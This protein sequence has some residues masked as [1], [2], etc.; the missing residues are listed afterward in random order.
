[1][2]ASSKISESWWCTGTIA[3]FKLREPC[4]KHTFMSHRPLVPRR[5]QGICERFK[6]RFVECFVHSIHHDGLGLPFT[7]QPLVTFTMI[8]HRECVEKALLGRK[9]WL[10]TNLDLASILVLVQL[11]FIYNIDFSTAPRLITLRN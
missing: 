11:H 6:V 8:R 2:R 9:R 1:V 10:G 3:T 5:H 7:R 4:K